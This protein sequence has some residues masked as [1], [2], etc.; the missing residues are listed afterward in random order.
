MFINGLGEGKP[1]DNRILIT[2]WDG[3]GKDTYDLSLYTTNLKLDLRP[4]FFSKFSDEQ[5]CDLGFRGGP[6]HHL[7]RGNITN[8][9]LYQGDQRSLIE[10]AIG[11]TGND[12]IVGN[13]AANRLNGGQGVDVLAGGHS[14]DSLFGGDQNDNLRGEAGNDNILAG[15]GNDRL[16]GGDGA[17][18]LQGEQGNDT[19]DGGLGNDRI[20]GGTGNDQLTGGSGANQFR[21][22]IG[23]GRDVV[24]DFKDDVDTISI[25]K[26]FGFATVQDILDNCSS[27]GGDSTINLRGANFPR[28]ILLGLDDFNKFAND[29]VLI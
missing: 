16:G 8:A 3:N 15:T 9:L 10:N 12:I 22:L 5:L 13:H 28:V 23:S 14:N 19:I 6:G 24:H 4:G 17:D 26:R 18:F 27:S 11:G 1:G 29:I 20:V 7:A 2:L 21:F 25:D